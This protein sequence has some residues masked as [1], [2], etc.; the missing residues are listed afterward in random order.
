V[1]RHRNRHEVL[2]GCGQ[3]GP[4]SNHRFAFSAS[5]YFDAYGSYRSSVR[6]SN[7]LSHDAETGTFDLR[8]QIPERRARVK[9]AIA[10]KGSESLPFVLEML[11]STDSEES[12]DAKDVLSLMGGD[13]QVTDSLIDSIASA[14][15]LD[16][17]TALVTALGATR[18]TRS[19]PYLARILRAPGIDEAT[20]KAAVA[21]LGQLINRQLGE[22]DEPYVAALGWL[23]ENGYES[24]P[25][26][27]ASAPENPVPG[28]LVHVQMRTSRHAE[29]RRVTRA[30]AEEAKE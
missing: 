9:L 20:L 21:S 26:V 16:T 27:E 29:H 19:V 10:S 12:Q 24:V 18:N 22:T 6:T 13:T 30:S 28:G 17:V 25:V 8:A 2:S 23:A 3:A 15:D 5:F 4:S 7:T 14:T 1:L 11:R